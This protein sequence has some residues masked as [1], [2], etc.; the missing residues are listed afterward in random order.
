MTTNNNQIDSSP[1]EP[2]FKNHDN[3]SNV[4]QLLS[5]GIINTNHNDKHDSDSKS[6]SS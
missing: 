5:I 4:D 3:E 6:N 1:S 2:Q